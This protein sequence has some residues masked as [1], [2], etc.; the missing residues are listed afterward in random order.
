M[1]CAQEPGGAQVTGYRNLCGL[2]LLFF[3]EPCD[4]SLV[5]T[6][7]FWT[8]SI[9]SYPWFFPLPS[10]VGFSLPDFW[11]VPFFSW[12][13]CHFLFSYCASGIYCVLLFGKIKS[14]FFNEYQKKCFSLTLPPHPEPGQ[15][16]RQAK[17]SESCSHLPT[18]VCLWSRLAPETGSC[19]WELLQALGWGLEP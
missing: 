14:L 9:T 7:V 1:A 10:Y 12:T 6:G 11:F 5:W 2:G 8:C 17:A 19:E 16:Q 4:F 15:R 13:L 3:Q 18:P